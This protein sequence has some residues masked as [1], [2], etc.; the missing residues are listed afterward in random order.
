MAV[1]IVQELNKTKGDQV[2]T[3]SSVCDF[4][5]KY[6]IGITNDHMVK[7][8]KKVNGSLVANYIPGSMSKSI[9]FCP[10]EDG[11]PA[12]VYNG[13]FYFVVGSEKAPLAKYVFS[14]DP[15]R[16]QNLIKREMGPFRVVRFL[17]NLVVDFSSG[18]KEPSL[19]ELLMP[20][21]ITVFDLTKKP[22]SREVTKFFVQGN[23]QRG[24]VG[25]IDEK[26]QQVTAH[27]AVTESKQCF[28]IAQYLKV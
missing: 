3:F 4:Y 23:T 14:Y 6:T 17:G 22:L 27:D 25:G 7:I 26:N 24:W 21:L 11:N 15:S 13:V 19:L 18:F 8:A 16:T 9:E 10:D 28:S 20:A 12:H 2:P 1:G 5:Q